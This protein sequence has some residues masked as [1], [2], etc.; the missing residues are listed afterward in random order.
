MSFK[1]QDYLESKRLVF[2]RFYFLSNDELLD[3]LANSKDVESVQPYLN[4]CFGNILHLQFEM[5]ERPLIPI[6]KMYSNEG[7]ALELPR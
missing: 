2:S 3:I 5:S 1:F 4:K 6:T 7:E